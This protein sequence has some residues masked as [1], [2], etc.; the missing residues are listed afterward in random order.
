MF[1]TIV[2]A[3]LTVLV[4]WKLI[5]ILSNWLIRRLKEPRF[6]EITEIIFG[7]IF[8]MFLVGIFLFVYLTIGIDK[9][10]LFGVGFPFALGLVSIG[11]NKLF[12]KSL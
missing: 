6:R 9:H 12:N 11:I 1:W 4:L 8:I 2:S 10:I 7:I 3:L 5:I